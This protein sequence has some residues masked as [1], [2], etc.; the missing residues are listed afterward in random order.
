MGQMPARRQRHAEDGVARLEK[1]EQHRL[2]RLRAG[3]RL[4]VDEAAIE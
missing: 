3:M 2:V 1:R 4:D